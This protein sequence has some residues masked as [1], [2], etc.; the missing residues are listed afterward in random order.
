MNR[1]V[2]ELVAD[3]DH[4][5]E[6]TKLKMTADKGIWLF[7]YRNT[8]LIKISV[9]DVWLLCRTEVWYHVV[10]MKEVWPV[11]QSENNRLCPSACV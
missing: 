11:C 7:L 2:E 8:V 5:G 6:E 10:S 9:K 4:Q 1:L 3:Q